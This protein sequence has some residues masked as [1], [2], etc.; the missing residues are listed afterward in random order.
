M[1]EK[2]NVLL[3]E[4]PEAREAVLWLRSYVDGQG[5]A[6]EAKE[7][8]FSFGRD[9]PCAFLTLPTAVPTSFWL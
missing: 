2:W 5:G 1:E 3:E 8:R 7:V 4:C 6:A 9:G